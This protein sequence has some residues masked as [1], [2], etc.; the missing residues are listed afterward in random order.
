MR[1]VV[2]EPC[3]HFACVLMLRCWLPLG[4]DRSGTNGSARSEKLSAERALAPT[5]RPSHMSAVMEKQHRYG[6]IDGS[7]FRGKRHDDRH[8]QPLALRH[9]KRRVNP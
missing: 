6:K 8:P 5:M 2:C 9:R 7:S 3:S 1:H 4:Q